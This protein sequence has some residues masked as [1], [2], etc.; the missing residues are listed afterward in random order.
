MPF[1]GVVTS[2]ALLLLLIF[3][4]AE[5]R[6]VNGL[7][8][9]NTGSGV[10]VGKNV[11]GAALMCYRK[12]VVHGEVGLAK[13]VIKKAPLAARFDAATLLR[14][15]AR[16]AARFDAATLLRGAAR[17]AA[18]FDAATL[19]RVAARLAARFD[20]AT[21]LLGP[22]LPNGAGSAPSPPMRPERCAPPLMPGA[23]SNFASAASAS[24]EDTKG[25]NWRAKAWCGWVVVVA[26]VIAVFVVRP[27]TF[28]VSRRVDPMSTDGDGTINGDDAGERFYCAICM[29]T[30]PGRLKFIVAPCGHAFCSSCVAQYVAAKLGENSARV[31]CP[32]PRCGGV[33]AVDPESCRGILSRDLLDKWGL[34]LCESALGAKKVYCPYRECSAPLL[35]DGGAA[36]A[37]I[38]EAECPH[39][40]RLFCARCAV[41]WHAGI[42]VLGVPA[43]RA[44]RARAGGPAAQAARRPAAVAAVPQVP[45]VRGEIGRLQL[46][47]M[48]V[49]TQFLLQMCIRG[50]RGN[51]LL[52]K[53]QAL[54]RFAWLWIEISC[55]YYGRK[56]KVAEHTR[57]TAL[58]KITNT[59]AC[60]WSHTNTNT[61]T[62][63]TPTST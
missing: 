59:L 18:R 47:Q 21:L 10:I 55:E 27:E 4:L 38:M 41:P 54:A 37:A 3:L 31:E 35:T 36:A 12:S 15:A 39:C 46:H 56:L 9:A 63:I 58:Y 23:G 13:T 42:G 50:V 14:G 53:V 19:L 34:L 30:V 16:L 57:N 6:P 25:L 7:V 20:A 28:L 17:L 51:P 45:H 49:W 62:D 22:V 52:Q 1:A 5:G 24:A 61:R 32:D 8:P 33:G 2:S 11:T 48:Q 60:C 44:G 29:E 26:L 43:A 40:H